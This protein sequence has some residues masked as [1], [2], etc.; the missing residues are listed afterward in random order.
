MDGV[1]SLDTNLAM[2]YE[3]EFIK[4]TIGLIGLYHTCFVNLDKRIK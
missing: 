2:L 3:A 1:E 4:D